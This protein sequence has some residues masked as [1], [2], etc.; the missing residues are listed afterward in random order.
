MK[1]KTYPILIR[2]IE[3]G[4]KAGIVRAVKY[5]PEPSLEHIEDVIATEVMNAIDGVFEFEGVI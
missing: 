4:V 3:E 5:D 2:A 1:A